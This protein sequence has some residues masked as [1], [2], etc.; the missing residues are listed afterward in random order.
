ME[1]AFYTAK[2]NNFFPVFMLLDVALTFYSTYVSP[3]FFLLWSP[4]I[5][6][7][8]LLFQ[9]RLQTFS[10]GLSL[11][12]PLTSFDS[13]SIFLLLILG[14]FHTKFPKSE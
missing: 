2:S 7:L 9:Q 5:T 10:L 1:K 6:L 4:S 13:S 12:D 3:K 11:P 14:I 8:D